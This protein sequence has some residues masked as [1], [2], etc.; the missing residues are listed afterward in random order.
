MMLNYLKEVNGQV[1]KSMDDTNGVAAC[2]SETVGE[3]GVTLNVISEISE[4]TNL[5]ALNASIE[6]ARAG[7]AGKGFAVVAQ[8]V[9]KLAGSTDDSLGKS[10]ERRYPSMKRLQKASVR[11]TGSSRIFPAW[12]TAI[13]QISFI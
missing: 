11:K 13:R 4:S 12:W 1:L 9:G 10:S 7:E 6:A 8:E 5:L 3:I 2:L